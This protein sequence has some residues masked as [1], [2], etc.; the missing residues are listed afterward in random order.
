M[1]AAGEM[2]DSVGYKSKKMKK[3]NFFLINA[4]N[5]KMKINEFFFIKQD[6]T[7]EH[8]FVVLLF[9]LLCKSLDQ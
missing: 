7:D 5:T 1:L 9:L 6:R 8:F 3:K 2:T 4:K